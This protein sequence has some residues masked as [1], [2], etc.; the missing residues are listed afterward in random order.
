MSKHKSKKQYQQQEQD[1]FQLKTVSPLTLNQS[2]IFSCW[3]K[4]HSHLVLH[5]HPGTG[6]TYVGMYL[7]L[8]ELFSNNLYQK[9]V[10]FRSVVPSRDIGF[11]PGSEKE[12]ARIYETPYKEIC[13]EL[14]QTKGSYDFLKTRGLIEFTTSSFLR[15]LT[16][17]NSIVIVDEFQNMSWNEIFAILTRIGIGSRVILCGDVRQ[18]DLRKH[19]HG[20]AKHI[21]NITKKMKSFE[22]IELGENDIVRSDFVKELIINYLEYQDTLDYAIA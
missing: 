21:I 1:T 2:R 22:F 17:S 18:T 7:A 4:K 10:V 13:D 3:E 12:K 20:A 8:R 16:F 5:G 11:L 14:Y 15:G 6:K 19:E 9:I